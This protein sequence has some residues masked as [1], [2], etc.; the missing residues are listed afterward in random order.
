MKKTIKA[1]KF[2]IAFLLILSSFIAC[3]KD[4]NVIESDVLGKE[5]SNFTTGETLLP[6]VAYNKKLDSLQVNNLASNLLGVFNDPSY[7]STTASIV[8]QVTPT[9][10]NPDFG[11]DPVIDSIVINIPYFSSQVGTDDNGN[12][13]Y[14]LDS[15][16]G[17]PTAPIK[18]TLYQNNYFLRDL[19]PNATGSSSQIY[20]SNSNST[21]NSVLNGTSTINFDDHIVVTIH[22]DNNFIPSEAAIEIWN[23]TDSD[24]TTT[25]SVPAYRVVLE[26]DA[27]KLFWKN[28]IIDKQDDPVLSNANNFKNYFRGVYLK[29]EALVGNGNMILL[30]LASS[31]ANITINYTSGETDSRTRS[32]YVMSFTGNRLNTF[33]NDFNLV[34]L[35]NGNKQLGDDKL[36]LKGSAGSM[37]VVDLFPNGLDDFLDTFR[38]PNGSGG[39]EKDNDGNYILNRL[40]NEAHLAIYEDENI[41]NELDENGDAYHK[42]DRIFAYDI[43]NNSPTIDYL[44]DVT[45]NTQNP[46]S[47]KVISLSQRDTITAKFKI[48]LTEHLNNIL[49]R[50]STNTKIGLVTSFNV[51]YNSTVQ[52]LNSNDEVTQIPAANIISPRGTILHGSNSNVP[53]GKQL[54]FKIF[55]TEPN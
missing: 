11:V 12:T 3:D 7:G 42:Y 16:Y 47:S 5:N 34:T 20:Y 22:E 32:T 27:D 23:I 37:S 17:D 29:A 51:N 28:T 49:L 26:D 39:Y 50:D 18:L 53:E 54:K 15:L 35:Q 48:R 55:F 52:I 10:F 36:Y 14:A 19:D 24:T 2:P 44:I 33:I 9:S 6:I 21:T 4:F 41:Y 46:I 25:R 38:V 43:K 13:T 45:E 30:N 31:N 40:I 8:T 1:F